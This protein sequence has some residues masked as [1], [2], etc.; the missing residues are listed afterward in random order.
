MLPVGCADVRAVDEDGVDIGPGQAATRRELLVMT[1]AGGQHDRME[2][3]CVTVDCS[4]PTAVASFWNEALGWG[5][6]AVSDGGAICGPP[7]GGIYLEFV[8]VP[9]AKQ[10]KNRLHLGCSAGGL[11]DL[12]ATIA[13]LE[14]LGGVVAWEEE[15]PPETAAV[16]RNVVLRDVEG[17]EFCLGGG[18]FPR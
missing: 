17:N 11:D 18:T 16:Y 8:R 13:R 9:E 14:A 7:D 10:V 6:V 1:A 15:F 5:G 2:L 4:D 3:V 12:Q